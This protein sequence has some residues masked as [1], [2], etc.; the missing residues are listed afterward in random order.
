MFKTV[1][2]FDIFRLRLGR[3]NDE[4]KD[5]EMGVTGDDTF[6]DVVRDFSRMAYSNP[7]KLQRLKHDDEDIK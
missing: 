6:N 3:L 2:I 4:M 1:R 7:E 5:S